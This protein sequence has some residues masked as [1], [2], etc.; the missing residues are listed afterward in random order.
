MKATHVPSN[1]V[2]EGGCGRERYGED[3]AK[4]KKKDNIFLQDTFLKVGHV[5]SRESR[6][7]LPP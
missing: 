7:G 5:I 1:I 6:E 4:D 3:M 2:S